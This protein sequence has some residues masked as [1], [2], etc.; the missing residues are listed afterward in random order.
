LE[1]VRHRYFKSPQPTGGPCH[2]QLKAA[3][4]PTISSRMTLPIQY[5]QDIRIALLY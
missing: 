1:N 3:M 4:E 2:P 5:V